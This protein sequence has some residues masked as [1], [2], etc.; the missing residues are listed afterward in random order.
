MFKPG[1]E[2]HA[3]APPRPGKW[4]LV[5]RAQETPFLAQSGQTVTPFCVC[6]ELSQAQGLPQQAAGS[7]GC[8]LAPQSPLLHSLRPQDICIHYLTQAPTGWQREG[9]PGGHADL[10]S[11]R[12]GQVRG[13]VRTLPIQRP[14]IVATHTPSTPLP[15]TMP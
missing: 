11:Q 3:Q 9:Q 10:A 15:R 2:P 6:S 14:F 7:L 12:R 8:P 5:T 13:N 1:R 4:K